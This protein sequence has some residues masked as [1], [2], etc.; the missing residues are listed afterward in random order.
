M[1]GTAGVIN[2]LSIF[3]KNGQSKLVPV[4]V[5]VLESKGP[6]Y[7]TLSWGVINHRAFT[8]ITIRMRKQTNKQTARVFIDNFFS[9]TIVNRPLLNE[10]T[11]AKV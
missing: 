11:L 3:A 2:F 7:S 6:C 9:V 1:N 5:F 10:A 8:V 4:L